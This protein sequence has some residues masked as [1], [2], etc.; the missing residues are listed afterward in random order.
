MPP[1]QL[2]ASLK[3]DKEKELNQIKPNK[4][5]DKKTKQNKQVNKTRTRQK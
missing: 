1:E 5:N 3:G 2:H 4:N